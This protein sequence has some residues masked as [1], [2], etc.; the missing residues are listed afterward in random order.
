M[1]QSIRVIDPLPFGRTRV[2]GKRHRRKIAIRAFDCNKFRMPRFAAN[3]T[4][5]FNE[6]EFP[7]RFARARAAGFTA[8]EFLFPYAYSPE[9]VAG[10]LRAA[11]VECVLFNLPPGDFEAGER[12][13]A[14]IPGREAEFADSVERAIAFARALRVP[15]LHAM[16]GLRGAGANLETYT[17]NLRHAA[18]RLAAHQIELLIEPINP[19]DMPG[20]LLASQ[21]E[22]LEVIALVGEPNLRLQ[23][24]LYHLQITS[25]DLS[26]TLER[27][28]AWIGHVQIAGVPER[29]EPDSGEIAYPEVFQL[30][31]RLGY[32]GWIGCE[33]RP[34]GR[35]E[36]GLGWLPR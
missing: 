5:M 30:L 22:A 16:A 32:T 7:Q 26:R 11:N 36:D 29:H 10:W 12:G 8:V 18:R 9:M 13:I 14:A 6:V 27:D 3:L 31:D 4:M 17:D 35:T 33:Y 21:T 34:R 24:D 2:E 19:R 20:Y 23:C 28:I 15:R 25:G 1:G